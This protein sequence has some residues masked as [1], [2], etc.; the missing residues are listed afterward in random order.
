MKKRRM[1]TGEIGPDTTEK[2]WLELTEEE[3]SDVIRVIDEC[4]FVSMVLKYK[5]QLMP[6]D[7]VQELTHQ[8]R[9]NLEIIIE[10]MEKVSSDIHREGDSLLFL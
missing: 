7:L 9:T 6:D 1:A 5:G 10:V 8:N 2:R 4:E 3:K